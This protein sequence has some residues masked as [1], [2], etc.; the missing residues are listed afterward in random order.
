VSN[1]LKRLGLM[2]T[3]AHDADVQA[4]AERLETVRRTNAQTRKSRDRAWTFVDACQ[5]EGLIPK[6]G[7]WGRYA[8]GMTASES[9]GD[10][11]RDIEAADA[12]RATLGPADAEVSR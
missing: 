11:Q 3:A 2:T 7:P 6:R 9:E 12:L 1:I 5:R 10:I 4:L 8:N